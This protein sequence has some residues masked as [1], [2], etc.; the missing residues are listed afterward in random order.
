MGYGP[1]AAGQPNNTADRQAASTAL[2]CN[3]RINV[4]TANSRAA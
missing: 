3:R 2:A 4:W 1:P